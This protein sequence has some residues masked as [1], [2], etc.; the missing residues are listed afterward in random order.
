MLKPALLYKEKINEL[1]VRTWYDPEYMYF[2]MGSGTEQYHFDD[3]NLDRHQFA[4]VDDQDNVIGVITY[5]VDYQIMSATSVGIISFQK[6][7]RTFMRDL[8]Q[9]VEDIFF[10]YNMNRLSFYAVADNPA[11]R[12]YKNFVKRYGGTICGYEHECC[13]LMD[14]T[15]HDFIAFEIMAKD[16]KQHYKRRNKKG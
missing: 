16:F 7:N 12:G 2:T 3:N 9:A 5:R 4:S 6:M 8:R 15:L 11:V 1:Y 13:K 10:K 14:G